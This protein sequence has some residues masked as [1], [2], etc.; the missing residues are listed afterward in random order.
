MKLGK[1]SAGYNLNSSISLWK[2]GWMDIRKII[3]IKLHLNSASKIIT[4][5]EFRNY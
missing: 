3:I 1:S 5:L 2:G 4:S